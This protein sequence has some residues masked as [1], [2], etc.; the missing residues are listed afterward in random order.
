MALDLA[1]LS[2]AVDATQVA[3]AVAEL[4]KLTDAGK[5]TETATSATSQALLRYQKDV[6][7]MTAA[8]G[9]QTQATSGMNEEQR[10]LVA[11]LD[12]LTSSYDK[13]YK[14]QN[15]YANG[16]DL[17]N[18]AHKAGIVDNIAYA[19]AVSK[20]DARMMAASSTVNEFGITANAAARKVAVL[21]HELASGRVRQ[22]EGTLLSLVQTLLIA[23]PILVAIG[24]AVT[25]LIAV[26]IYGLVHA[27]N[28]NR[29]LNKL[30][31]QFVASGRGAEVSR[32]DI[33]GF[34][35][36]LARLPGISQ[37]VATE[38]VKAFSETARVSKQMM[39]EALKLVP[40]FAAALGVDAPKAAQQLAKALE[41]P[42]KGIFELDKRMNILTATQYA[43]AIS[44]KETGNV[45]G[46]QQ[47][48]IDALGNR[49]KGLAE[50]EMTSWQKSMQEL[51]TIWI[52]LKGTMS[53]TSFLDEMGRNFVKQIRLTIDVATN[54]FDYL[55]KI[56]NFWIGGDESSTAP[57]VN[58][59]ATLQTQA[60]A[61]EIADSTATAN[62]I[63][64]NTKA[65]EDLAA[66]YV[67]AT[68]KGALLR[69]DRLKLT[70]AM[71]AAKGTDSGSAQVMTSL[72]AGIAAVDE[73]IAALT[74]TKKEHN[75]GSAAAI[76]A[77]KIYLQSVQN[78]GDGIVR[79]SEAERMLIKIQDGLYD[80]K[81]P[82]AAIEMMKANY[83]QATSQEAVNEAQRRL[84]ALVKEL[85]DAQQ[86]QNDV[87]DKYLQQ[88]AD[89]LRKLQ[90]EQDGI[91]KTSLEIRK[92]TVARQLDADLRKTIAASPL[93]S[94]AEV[95]ALKAAN[96]Q[97][98]IQAD[99]IINVSESMKAQQTQVDK[100]S[101]AVG[102]FFT[103]ILVKGKSV[104]TS[105]KEE[106]AKF[107]DYLI[108]MFARQ[109]I[110]NIAAGGS[111]TGSF[112]GA[113]STVGTNL[114]TGGGSGT[115]LIGSGLSAGYNYLFGGASSGAGAGA[116]VW[117]G[118]G[119]GDGA[120][121]AGGAGAGGL[122]TVSSVGA[123]VGTA[124]LGAIAGY[125]IGGAL[126]RNNNNS[127]ATGGA[128]GGGVGA[129]IGAYATAGSVIGPWG[130]VIGAVLGA[131]V[132]AFAA[133]HGGKK[134][135]GIAI[136]W[137]VQHGGD[138]KSV[139]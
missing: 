126:S 136:V 69:E 1:S 20:L 31:V 139:V 103:D 114:M 118:A 49:I 36:E 74:K 17:L 40:D 4:D 48:L 68:D 99:N 45:A 32:S 15:T 26:F 12:T 116:N 105:L 18:K 73:K 70:Q 77:S 55:K 9:V 93:A 42:L 63:S 53:D 29:E 112:A 27:E 133:D 64:L 87:R 28:F 61:R 56:K 132:G 57:A 120:V 52:Q 14:A 113:L 124:A 35:D 79:L 125:F 109:F 60:R 71:E 91:G 5:R 13:A 62:A 123:A 98:K 85:T 6:T 67:R 84:K 127:A 110:L 111:F 50:N 75:D 80:G 138:R 82:K 10:K 107:F 21:T 37:S 135:E 94:D 11:Q 134:E 38:V 119:Y 23:Q 115:S 43:T 59:S 102:T 33:R 90:D 19:E 47:M 100:L 95:A 131:V 137:M 16:I 46:A 97:L 66:A 7:T 81:Y 34:I 96:E 24:L 3:P 8:L 22:F 121:T 41:D 101:A 117:A 104:A 30:T 44:M 130:A 88:G 58:Q 39:A 86:A 76:E 83:E 129:A 128:V 54:L 25:A 122:G 106:F 108:Q 78:Q 92:L 2:I 72:A 89:I 65:A 51:K